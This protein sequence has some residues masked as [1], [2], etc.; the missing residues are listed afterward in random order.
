ML[1]MEYYDFC[2]NTM[3]SDALAPKVASASADMVFALLDR[4]HEF[5]FQS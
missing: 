4:Q 5:L 2:G 1:E 3:P